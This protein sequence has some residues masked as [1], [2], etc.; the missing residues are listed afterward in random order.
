M[1]RSAG[2]GVAGS[3]GFDN[4][5]FVSE[6]EHAD[7]NHALSHYMK[8]AGV[9]PAGTDIAETLELYFEAC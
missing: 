6:R 1:Q 3:V 4:G 8:E 9:I 7:R 2:G 5:V